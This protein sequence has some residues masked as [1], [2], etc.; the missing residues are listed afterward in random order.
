MTLAKRTF[1]SGSWKI[2]SNAI[3]L[4]ISFVRSIILAR[5][6]PVDIFGVFA[7]AGSIT[8]LSVIL[9]DFGMAGALI[10]RAP[11]TEDLDQAAAVQFTFRF[12]FTLV[13]A[14]LLILGTL[15]FTEPNSLLRTALFCLIIVGLLTQLKSTPSLILIRKVQQRRQAVIEILVTLISTPLMIWLAWQGVTLWV[16]LTGE[17]VGAGV[18]L[19]MYY[20]WRPVWRPRFSFD[21]RIIRYF[22]DF[23][24]RNVLNSILNKALDLIDDIWVGF[25]LGQTAT[26]FY[27]KAYSFAVYPRRIFAN[28]IN[29]VIGGAY[30]E[31]KGKRDRL[32]E[33][34]SLVN[35]LLIRSS[36]F[37]GG[38]LVLIAPEFIFVLLGDKWL[39]MLTTFRLMLIFTLFDPLKSTISSVISLAGGQPQLVVKARFIQLTIMIVGIFTL[40]PL[41][42]IN[43]V[44][45]AVDLMLVVGIVIL[46]LQARPFVDYSIRELFAIPLFGLILGLSAVLTW[47]ALFDLASFSPWELLIIKSLLFSSIYLTTLLLFEFQKIKDLF[48]YLQV[49]IRN[50]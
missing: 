11:E 47:G 4:A 3:A 40:G 34:F 5:L 8:K 44:A 30:A 9:A 38:F 39:P 36:F 24:K 29:L 37:L 15:V 7:F 19:L 23:G 32:S 17:I 50:R 26:G 12:L 10:H 31:L 13:W 25:F 33:L 21:K 46:F 14:G 45:I 41:L 2:G 49:I 42:G 18:S 1:T 6:L 27:N 20:G 22:F 48:A 16:L 43:G 28:P 35:T